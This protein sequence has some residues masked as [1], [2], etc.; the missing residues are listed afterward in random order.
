[1]ES[2]LAA[3]RDGAMRHMYVNLA[4]DRVYEQHQ[5]LHK[6]YCSRACVNFTRTHTLH[7]FLREG[8]TA[9]K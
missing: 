8:S 9:A 7:K 3:R 5:R 6:I 4:Q 1:M 2:I